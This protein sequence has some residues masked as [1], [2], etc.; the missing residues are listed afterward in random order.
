MV[1][2]D[3]ELIK[4]IVRCRE[5]YKWNWGL[6]RRQVNRQFDL[7]IDAATLRNLYKQIQSHKRDLKTAELA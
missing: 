2:C 6:T 7:S 5:E 4:T 3:S 1:L